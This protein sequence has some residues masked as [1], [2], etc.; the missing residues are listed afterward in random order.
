[1]VVEHLFGKQGLIAARRSR[2]GH[3]GRVVRGQNGNHSGYVQ[4]AGGIERFEFGMGV[5]SQHGPGVQQV[6]KTGQQVVRVERLAGDVPSGA[7][8]RKV[9]AD[10]GHAACASRVSHQN[11][12]ISDCERASRYAALPR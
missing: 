3:A 4:R 10:R 11:F 1:M 8:M 5:R 7:F 9:L 2:I 6:R 12:S